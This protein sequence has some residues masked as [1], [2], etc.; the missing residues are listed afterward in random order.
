MRVWGIRPHPTI[1]GF[2][3]LSLFNKNQGQNQEHFVHASTTPTEVILT[4]NLPIKLAHATGARQGIGCI[5]TACMT[6]FKWELSHIGRS[7]QRKCMSHL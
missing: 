6:V 4:A 7:R 3:S 1:Q 2:K 5:K